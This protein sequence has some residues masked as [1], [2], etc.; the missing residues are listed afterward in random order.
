MQ[1][2]LVSGGCFNYK[3]KVS[4]GKREAVVLPE[5]HW[6][7][8]RAFLN[9]TISGGQRPPLGRREW[10]AVSKR[11]RER[12]RWDRRYGRTGVNLEAGTS[13]PRGCA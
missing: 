4:A 6:S 7:F 11:G 5:G 9:F 8:C 12:E 10:E 13:D 2:E 3:R 1:Q